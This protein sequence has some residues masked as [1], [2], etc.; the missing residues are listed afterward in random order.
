VSFSEK[1]LEKLIMIHQNKVNKSTKKTVV[2]WMSTQ[3]SVQFSVEI[4]QRIVRSLFVSTNR[5]SGRFNRLNPVLEEIAVE[6]G[7]WDLNLLHSL[8]VVNV[9]QAFFDL[10]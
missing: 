9:Q 7:K 6:L 8:I 10:R 2:V 4:L 1:V 3:V 5:E